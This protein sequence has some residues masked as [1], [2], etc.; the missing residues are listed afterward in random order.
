MNPWSLQGA[1]KGT[2]NSL[3]PYKPDKRLREPLKET[4]EMSDAVF[5]S[6]VMTVPEGPKATIA[7][8]FSFI[9]VV[10]GFRVYGIM[11]VL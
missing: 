1:L 6:T 11:I 7:C 2:L 5:D 9:R 8:G 3:R 10:L 4:W